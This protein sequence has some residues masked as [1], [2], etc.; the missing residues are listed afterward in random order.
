MNSNP[1]AFIY[2][3]DV[4]I[5]NLSANGDIQ[6]TLTDSDDYIPTSGAIVEYVNS[7]PESFIYVTDVTKENLDANGDIETTIS[8]SDDVIP[9]SGAIV[10]YAIPLTQK[11][12]ANG[13]ATLG[14]DTKIPLSQIPDTIVGS[15]EYQGTWDADTNTPT[16]PNASGVKGDYYV[17]SVAGTYETIA[18]NIGDW[19]IS[20]GTNWGK[21]DNT[22]QV[23]SVF[24]RQGTITAQANDYTWAQIDKTTS[25]IV[26]ITSR[27]HTDLTDIGTNSHTDID[28]HIASTSNPHSVTKTQVGLSNVTNDAQLKA[29][30][31]V[32]TVT[33]DDTKVPSAGAIVDYVNSNPESFIYA[34]DVTIDNLS[35][36]GDVQTTITDVDTHVPTSGAVVDYAIP[37]T[38]KAAVNGVATLDSGGKVPTSQLPDTIVGSVEYQGT[39]DAD[40]DDP[41]LPAASGVKGD[42][43]VVSVA[44]TYE[45]VDYNIGDWI[46]SNGTSWEK[47]DNTDA[48]TSV[49]GRTGIVVAADNDYTWAQIDKTTSDIADITTKSHTSLTDIGTYSHTAIDGHITTA[50][51]NPHAVTKTEIGLSNVTND[52]QLTAA[53]LE[54]TITDDDAKVPSSGAVVDYVATNPGSYITIASV[55]IETLDANGDLQTTISDI[56]TML[57]SSGAVVDYVAATSLLAANLETTITDDDTKVPSSGAV[58]DYVAAAGAV[59]EAD[60]STAD[61]GFVLD[62]DDMASDSA[63]KLATQQSIKA[64][65]DTKLPKWNPSITA[66]DGTNEGGQLTFEGAGAYGDWDIDIFH[67]RMRFLKSGEKA[68]IYDDGRVGLLNG[69]EYPIVSKT[70]AYTATINDDVILCD[71]TFT[72]TLPAASTATGCKLNIK[73]I[74]TGTIT[75][76]GDGSE[77]I[78]GAI[79]VVIATQYA[80]YSIVCDGSAWHII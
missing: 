53:Q 71:G 11:A 25:D 3:S 57:P 28:T 26:D 75:I 63:T 2:A 27:S 52:A 9:T 37:L 35:T 59:M 73:N 77:T 29:A 55:T 38:Q 19:I 20:D 8:D 18:Y 4:T 72:V 68:T 36:N 40:I 69:A 67:D 49:F 56:D 58:V 23:S 13:V 16:L 34:T 60:T 74:G 32:T 76:D 78:D 70:S 5:D 30:D 17:V 66:A 24:G 15:V 79:T 10:D 22:D 44:G 61:M 54:T 65:A 51:G 48:V 47:V 39:W 12:A 14:A 31:L 50:S 80:S 21:V 1:E 6:T 46:I 42:Y 43:Y 33:D 45:T 64:Y 41:T 62:E 7:N